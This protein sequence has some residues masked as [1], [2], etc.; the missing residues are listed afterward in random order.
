MRLIEIVDQITGEWWFSC[1][2][3][4]VFWDFLFVFKIDFLVLY[5]N[6][7]SLIFSMTGNHTEITE[8]VTSIKNLQVLDLY[9]ASEPVHYSWLVKN[10]VQW[11]STSVRYTNQMRS[12]LQFVYSRVQTY[13]YWLSYCTVAD[14]YGF[15]KRESLRIPCDWYST[16]VREISSIISKKQAPFNNL[17]LFDNLIR[18]D[19]LV[20]ELQIQK[21]RNVKV[22][23]HYRTFPGCLLAPS[24]NML[25]L[26]GCLNSKFELEIGCN[27]VFRLLVLEKKLCFDNNS[28]R[29]CLKP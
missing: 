18:I 1:H 23:T 9:V 22:C 8:A 24:I 16:K 4:V 2:L 26:Y 6:V 14:V 25:F 3:S 28:V 13:L 15:C 5:V 10:P 21:T 7:F 29:R 12:S 11:F 27:N 20:E 17:I 19:K